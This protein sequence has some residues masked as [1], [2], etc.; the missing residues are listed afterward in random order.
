MGPSVDDLASSLNQSLD[1]LLGVLLGVHPLS[2]H[3]PPLYTKFQVRVFTEREE[4]PEGKLFII[5]APEERW[6]EFVQEGP[7]EGREDLSHS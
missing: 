4:F 1:P 6:S 5:S 2:L 3:V 7:P